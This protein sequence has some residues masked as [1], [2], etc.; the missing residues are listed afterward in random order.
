MLV[1]IGLLVGLLYCVYW[2]GRQGISAWYLR[3]NSSAAL[4]SALK[5][6]PANPQVFDNYGTLVHMYA[7]G[8]NREKIVD[9]YEVATRLSPQNAQYWADL[10]AAYDWAG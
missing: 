6:N 9:S 7:D 3:Q 10:G 1:R 2:A 5:W 8:G 4:E